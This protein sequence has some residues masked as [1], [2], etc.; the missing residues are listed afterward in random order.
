V[1]A[2]L[3]GNRSA[4]WSPIR[5]RLNPLSTPAALLPPPVPPPVAVAE[6]EQDGGQSSLWRWNDRLALVVGGRRCFLLGIV[7]G[8]VNSVRYFK[9]SW[10]NLITAVSTKTP[11]NS[12]RPTAP[13]TP[14]EVNP[15]ESI[16][17]RSPGA[18]SPASTPNM[19]C[20]ASARDVG[21]AVIWSHQISRHPAFSRHLHR[22]PRASPAANSEIQKK[23]WGMRYDCVDSDVVTLLTFRWEGLTS[24]SLPVKAAL[25]SERFCAGVQQDSR[26]HGE[27]KLHFLGG[28]GYRGTSTSGHDAEH[29]RSWSF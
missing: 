24:S 23:R 19:R 8:K 26:P 2:N 17:A 12:L 1:G 29:T 18:Q 21:S 25:A 9:R 6:G 3:S 13:H 27:H 20:S 7:T 28:V 4:L 16:V 11:L 5:F 15:P 10:R 22:S 14:E